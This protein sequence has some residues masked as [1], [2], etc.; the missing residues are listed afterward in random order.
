MNGVELLGL[1]D[2]AIGDSIEG[3][4]RIE[5]VLKTAM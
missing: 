5:D 2:G 3:V 4:A 1:P